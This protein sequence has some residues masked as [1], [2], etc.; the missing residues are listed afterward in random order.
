MSSLRTILR[1]ATSLA[2]VTFAFTILTSVNPAAAATLTVGSTATYKTIQAAV[3]AAAS[4]D[5][6][7]INPGYYSCATVSK[8]NLTLVGVGASQ[9]VISGKV[10]GDKALLVVSGTNTTIKNLQF[11]SAKSSSGNGAGIRMQGTNLTVLNSAF[12][13]NQDGVLSDYNTKSTITVQNS[14]FGKNGTCINP[15]GCGHGIY[16][17]HIGTLDVENST[18]ANTQAGHDIKSRANN[19]VVIGNKIQDT[20]TGTSS[21]LVDVPNGGAVTITG[22][23][24]EKGPKSSNSTAAIAMGEEGN[25]N[26]AGPLLIANNTFQNDDPKTQEFIW[27]KTGNANLTVSGNVLLGD[28][29]KVL[30]GPGAVST[31][32]TKTAAVKLASA[33]ANAAAENFAAMP[34]NARSAAT[35]VPEAPSFALFGSF[36]IGL[37]LFFGMKRR[38]QN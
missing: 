13:A 34:V 12:Y 8:S 37:G 27:N 29:T 17:G 16:A 32:T 26:P 25:L 31:P 3:N 22:N 28:T 24:L 36:L 11:T 23:Y 15:A 14:I 19:T 38:E 35:A 7:D 18:F 20:P 33:N 2:A 30:N 1:A 6:I 21:Y 10:C 9:P 4:G 5:T